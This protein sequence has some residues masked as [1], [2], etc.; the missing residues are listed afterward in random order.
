VWSKAVNTRQ[1]NNNICVIKSR[2]YKTPVLYLQLLITRILLFVCLVFT[3]FDH[4]YVIVWLSCIY[5]FWSHIFYCSPVLYLQ[6]L[7]T[8]ILLFDCLVFTAFDHTYVIVWLSCIY[9]FW[10]HIFYCSPVLYLQL[11]ITLIKYKT[12]KQ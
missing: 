3:A 8:R 11:L 5:S 7:I 2:K 9:S 6:L 10:S 1:S 4:T 12:V